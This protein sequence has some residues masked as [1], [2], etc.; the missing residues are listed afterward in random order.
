M[1]HLN[2]L[3]LAVSANFCSIKIDLSGL[4]MLNETFSVIFKHCVHALTFVGV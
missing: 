1:S 4:A 3:T 2:F